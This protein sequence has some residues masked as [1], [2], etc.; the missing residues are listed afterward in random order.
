M[1]VDPSKVNLAEKD[2]EDWLYEN[3]DKLR[4]GWGISHN[5][6]EWVGRQVKVPSGIIDLLGIFTS[7]NRTGF[8]IVEIKNTEFTQSSI[9]QVCRYASDI[10]NI[11]LDYSIET[12]DRFF[13]DV[14]KVVVAKGKPS[15]QLMFEAN[16]VNVQLVNFFVNYEMFFD[17]G[18]EFTSE[19]KKENKNI[20]D[21]LK[22][23]KDFRK[24]IDDYVPGVIEDFIKSIPDEEED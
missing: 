15:N 13:D 2:I 4:F 18:Y 6:K 24:Y 9:L 14:C 17:E 22:E 8:V 11:A 20:I 23:S 19:F 16:S 10:Q 1:K 7:S 21:N 5:V 12:N 3:P